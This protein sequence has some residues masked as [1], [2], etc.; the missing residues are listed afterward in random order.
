LD[1]QPRPAATRPESDFTLDDALSAI[2]YRGGNFLFLILAL[3]FYSPMIASLSSA[4]IADLR[5]RRGIE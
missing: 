2:H 4:V 1:D 5:V 3:F